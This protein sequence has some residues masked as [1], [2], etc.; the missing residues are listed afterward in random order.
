MTLKLQGV[1]TALITPFK[2]DGLDEE[3]LRRLVAWQ[4]EAGVHGLLACGTTGETPTLTADEY[5]RVVRVVVEAAGGRV[6]V[7]VGTGTN[8][9]KTTIERTRVARDLGADAALV[10][11]PYYNKPQQAGLVAHFEAVAREGGLP[12]VAYNV[13]GRTGVNITPETIVALSR[14]PGVIGVKEASGSTDPVREVV[15]QAPSFFAVLSGDDGLALASFALGA[16]GVI[17][18]ASNIAPRQ[19]VALWEAWAGG[20]THEAAQTD[21]VLA[22][23]YKALFLEPNPVPCKAAAQMLGLCSDFV[24]LPLVEASEA[25][26]KALRDALAGVGILTSG[27]S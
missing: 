17:S 22:P 11:A 7:L 1:L 9:T 23:L 13:P 24:R 10:V 14:L 26:R 20:R 8:C 12:V 25:T 21:R 27:A 4:L 2:G 19:M 5:M 15:R 18:V 6:P 3:A 16:R